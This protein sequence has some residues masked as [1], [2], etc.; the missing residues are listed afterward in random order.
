[1]NSTSCHDE[2][3]LTKEY[4]QS[5][6]YNAANLA[7]HIRQESAGG[8]APSAQ[9]MCRIGVALFTAQCFLPVC[10]LAAGPET[11]QCFA[12]SVGAV[13]CHS[14]ALTLNFKPFNFIEELPPEASHVLACLRDELKFGCAPPSLQR[15]LIGLCGRNQESVELVKFFAHTIHGSVCFLKVQC[16]LPLFTLVET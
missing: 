5:V 11:F 3:L 15:C 9:K 16:A 2:K 14:R 10:A 4:V 8:V 1:V 12:F 13:I 6:G 7:S